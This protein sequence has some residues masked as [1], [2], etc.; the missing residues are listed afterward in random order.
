MPY[1]ASEMPALPTARYFSVDEAARLVGV[2]PHVLRSWEAEFAS[3]LPSAVQRRHYRREEVLAAR[4]IHARLRAQA[5]RGG[6]AGLAAARALDAPQPLS[7][8]EL[9]TELTRIRETLSFDFDE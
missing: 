3:A 2:A 5:L 8:D 6:D 4:Q 1:A 9:R 7:V